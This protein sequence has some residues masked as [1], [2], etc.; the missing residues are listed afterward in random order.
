MIAYHFNEETFIYDGEQEC[1]LD[2]L[3]SE[4]AGH[5]IW[6]LPANCTWDK[7]LPY[8]EGYAS[9]WNGTSWEYEKLPD[10]IPPEPEPP[11]P[12]PPTLDEVKAAKISELKAIRDAK[13]VEFIYIDGLGMF[14]YDDKSRDRLSIARQ[15]LEDA[16][17]AGSITWTTAENQRVPLYIADFKAINATAA[18]R[19]NQLHI[20]YNELKEQV[21]AC[22]TI[23]EVEAIHWPEVEYDPLPPETDDAATEVV[24]EH[25]TIDTNNIE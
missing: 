13:E 9:K 3:E 16:D 4:I 18:V 2:P 22:T 12:E 24:N 11:E 21:N 15:A 7:P 19:S 8:K 23:E 25:E 20:T 17:D 14:D 10:P 1:Q 6:L 5:D